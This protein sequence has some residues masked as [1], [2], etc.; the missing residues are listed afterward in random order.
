MPKATLVDTPRIKLNVL[1]RGYPGGETI[2]FIHG[3]LSSSIFWKRTMAALADEFFCVAPDLRGFGGTE[4]LNVDAT[5]G[6]NDMAQDLLGLIE[7]LGITRF[8]LV[9]HSMGGGVAMKMMLLC[10]RVIASATLVNTISPYGYA[11]SSDE[12]GTPCYPDGSP[13][14]AGYIEPELVRRLARGDRSKENPLS[15]RNII[16]QLYFKPPFVAD[17]IDELLDAVLSTRVGEG[18]Y[19]G[20]TLESPYWD[21]LAPGE[22]GIVNAFSRRYFDASKIIDILPKPPILWL[23]GAEDSIICDDG[24]VANVNHKEQRRP[25]IGACPPQP[26]LRQIRSVLREYHKRGGIVREQL[27]HGAGHT[28]FIERPDEFERAFLDFLR[29]PAPPTNLQSDSGNYPMCE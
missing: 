23:R 11:G 6:L 17:N 13:G 16:E 10:P 19:P 15:P 29:S 28:P 5:L 9:G 3:N 20:N 1:T 14:G 26:M 8:H 24:A 4:P 2:L 21:G 27:I 22:R 7:C 18:W 12:N 25:E